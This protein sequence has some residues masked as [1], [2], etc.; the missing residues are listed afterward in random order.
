MSSKIEIC[1]LALSHFG[2]DSIDTV[3]EASTSARRCKLLY[4]VCRRQAL[5]SHVWAFALKT[6]QLPLSLETAYGWGY[7]YVL[8]SDNLRFVRVL[9]DGAHVDDKVDLLAT[10]HQAFEIAG[11]LLRS[12]I[13]SVQIEY[14]QDLTDTTKFTAA[15]VTAVSYLLA[16]HLAMSLTGNQA[17]SEKLLNL[18]V[19]FLAKAKDIDAASTTRVES[20]IG[21]EILE[22]GY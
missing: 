11:G 14:V 4:D 20:K 8:P 18:Y 17:V 10:K 7:V 16:S 3:D 15:F 12:N 5:E 2:Q 22:A 21:H 6:A 9:N 13:E 1:N 19:N